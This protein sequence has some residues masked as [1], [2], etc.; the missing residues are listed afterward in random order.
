ME[1]RY[2]GVVFAVV[3]GDLGPGVG[4]LAPVVLAG[5]TDPNLN[6]KTWNS[7]LSNPK[8]KFTF[9]QSF[10]NLGIATII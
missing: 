9:L 5:L 2:P 10:N 1:D 3:V 6:N 4:V 7:L 8:S